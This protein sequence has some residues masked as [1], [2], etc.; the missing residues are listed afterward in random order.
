MDG[1]RAEQGLLCGCGE[2]TGV[3]AKST[4]AQADKVTCKSWTRLQP[5]WLPDDLHATAPNRSSLRRADE[6]MYSG[7]LIALAD[8]CSSCR[9]KVSLR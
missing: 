8:A 3:L 7:E 2:G 1:D 4:R 6:V 5:D 9:R